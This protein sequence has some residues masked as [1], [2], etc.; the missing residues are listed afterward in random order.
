[1]KKWLASVVVMVGLCILAACGSN[2]ATNNES[3]KMVVTTTTGQIADVVKNIGGDNVDV[4]SLMGPG[5]DPH[6]Y[7][8]SQGDI[9]KLNDADII[10]YNGVHLEGKMGEIFE[11]IS[12]D[13]PTIA[14]AENIPKDQLLTQRVKFT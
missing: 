3:G 6:F 5:I 7:Q 4:T 12:K 13:K 2:Q 11:K 9:K 1:M 8:A 10:F 14:V